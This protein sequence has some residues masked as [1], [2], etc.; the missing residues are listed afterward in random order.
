MTITLRQ[1]RYFI[2]AVETGKMSAAAAQCGVSQSAVT[3]ALR[4]LEDRVGCPL[5]TRHQ[6]GVA[7]T[8]NGHKF[9]QKAREILATVAEATRSFDS[10]DATI[11]GSLTIGVTYTVMGY[12]I[13][14]HILRFKRRYAG[15]SLN[16]LQMERP[17]LEKALTDGAIDLAVM[18][19]SNVS[20]RRGISTQLLQSSPR[21]LWLPPGHPL[22]LQKNVSLADVAK[23]PYIMLTVDEAEQTTRRYWRKTSLS[24]N[25]ILSTSSVEAVR[26]FV[27]GGLGVT[28]LSDIIYR[29]WSLESERIERRSLSTPIPSMDIGMAWK[30]QRAWT[31]V[32]NEF[33]HIL[34]ASA[35]KLT[36]D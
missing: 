17:E 12:F 1:I 24:P 34:E 23:Q 13:G 4:E 3:I 14:P 16:V 30:S 19:V 36:E 32:A 5:L 9:L 31:P 28:L 11:S 35:V 7:L 26:S 2:A 21:R 10:A 15:V 27:A 22:L 8:G 18:L 6:S 20:N 25:V 33:V 29:P